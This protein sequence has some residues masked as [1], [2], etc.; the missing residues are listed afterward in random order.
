MTQDP[1]NNP[2]FINKWRTA[3]NGHKKRFVD[4]QKAIYKE[5]LE[6]NLETKMQSDKLLVNSGR[7]KDD[8]DHEVKVDMDGIT[9]FKIYTEYCMKQFDIIFKKKSVYRSNWSVED[10]EFHEKKIK[11]ICNNANKIAF[12]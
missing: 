11:K 12:D 8:N 6:K 1:K 4:Q 2:L 9:Y 3:V 7:F 5:I 10:L